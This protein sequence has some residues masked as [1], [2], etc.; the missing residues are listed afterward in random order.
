MLVRLTLEEFYAS[1]VKGVIKV[2]FKKII[3]KHSLQ[4]M[5]FAFAV[6][7]LI[8]TTLN[9]REVVGYVLFWVSVIA[10][11]AFGSSMHNS[12]KHTIERIKR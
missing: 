8:I 11:V 7:A 9:S 4:L 6:V 2:K 12:V 3:A 10:F 5:A 1:L